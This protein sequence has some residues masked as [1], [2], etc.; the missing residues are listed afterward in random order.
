MMHWHKMEILL[1]LNCSDVTFVDVPHFYPELS[2]YQISYQLLLVFVETITWVLGKRTNHMMRLFQYFLLLSET[3]CCLQF[4]AFECLLDCVHFS[5]SSYINNWTNAHIHNQ[6]QRFLC[7]WFFLIYISN[8]LH[9]T[10]YSCVSSANIRIL[11]PTALYD[12]LPE[13]QWY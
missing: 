2:S 5:P 10:K 8:R 9:F 7:L 1:I 4:N 11:S 13:Q 6:I 3:I 12:S